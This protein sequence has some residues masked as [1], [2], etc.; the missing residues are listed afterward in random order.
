MNRRMA[1]RNEAESTN[2]NA[3]EH[4]VD[5]SLT[6]RKTRK[7]GDTMEFSHRYDLLKTILARYDGYY[8][9]AAV[10]ASLLLTTN[11][12]LMAAL[13][14]EESGLSGILTGSGAAH[15]M[16]IVAAI[17]ALVS[18]L[19]SV[20]V[21]ASYLLTEK[22]SANASVFFSSSVAKTP[23]D[24]YVAQINSIDE[25]ALLEDLGRV[26]HHRAVG[27]VRKFHW[28]NLSLAA[29]LLA[30]LLATVAYLVD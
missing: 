18:T 11:V 15:V 22:G 17:L 28:I 25:A 10:K 24:E 12:I 27:L 7:P 26:A 9:L 21:L 19:F 5:N 8:H 20:F 3:R 29:F 23:L 14:S 6:E 16:L 4:T 30:L 2:E 13:V 1:R